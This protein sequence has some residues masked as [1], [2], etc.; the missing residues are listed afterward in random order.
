M[1]MSYFVFGINHMKGTVKFHDA[2]FE[3]RGI[4]EIHCEGRMSLWSDTH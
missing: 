2:L 1:N 3:S 4:S